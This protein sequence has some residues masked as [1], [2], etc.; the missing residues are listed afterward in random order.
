[1]HL[2]DRGGWRVSKFNKVRMV[3]MGLIFV[4]VYYDDI[5]DDDDDDDEYAYIL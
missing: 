4:L 2:G 5:D 3:E 1:M